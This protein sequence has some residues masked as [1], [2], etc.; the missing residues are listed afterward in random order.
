MGTYLHPLSDNEII[1][2]VQNNQVKAHFLGG[3]AGITAFKIPHNGYLLA[4][5]DHSA[6]A[7]YLPVGTLVSGSGETVPS[8]F[9]RYPQILGA[10]PLLLQSG[11]IVLDA[12][13]ERFSDAFIRE[14]AVRS[15]LGTTV[16]GTLLIAAVHNRVGGAGPTLA[17]IALVM[18]Q[19]GCVDAL[20]LDGGSSTNLYLGGRLLNRSPHNAARVH[21]GI[22][23]F[24]QMQH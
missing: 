2:I 17:E 24:L 16:P 4:L 12:K 11:Q 15:A 23:V 8:D 20:N 22:G 10:G 21:N 5:R 14:T 6:A 3:I 19:L 18:Q 13:A 1:V 9:G 7:S